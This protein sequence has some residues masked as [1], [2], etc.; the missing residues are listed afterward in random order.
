MEGLQGRARTQRPRP[1]A[2][3]ICSKGAA[4][5]ARS[6]PLWFAPS[7]PCQSYRLQWCSHHCESHVQLGSSP[8][9]L[10]HSIL[11]PHGRGLGIP[12]AP[13]PAPQKSLANVRREGLVLGGHLG[14]PVAKGCHA[15]LVPHLPWGASIRAPLAPGGQAANSQGLVPTHRIPPRLGRDQCITYLHPSRS[16]SRSHPVIHCS[17]CLR[18]WPRFQCILGP[19]TVP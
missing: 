2:K 3:S 15:G 6:S 11:P 9:S 13:R 19:R 14:L 5:P 12:R 1:L 4:P 8:S 7:T 17:R 18:T 10:A 16:L